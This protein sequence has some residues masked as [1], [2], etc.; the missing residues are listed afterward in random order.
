MGSQKFR[1][2]IPWLKLLR[3]VVC[4]TVTGLLIVLLLRT[5]VPRYLGLLIAGIMACLA[6]YCAIYLPWRLRKG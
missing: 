3:E 5:T 4:V 2:R 6:A 1:F